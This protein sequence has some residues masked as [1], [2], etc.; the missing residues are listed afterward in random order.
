METTRIECHRRLSTI[1]WT[2]WL[3]NFTFSR[4]LALLFLSFLS[5]FLSRWSFLGD[6]LYSLFSLSTLWSLP[7]FSLWCL[8]FV[9]LCCT[10]GLSLWSLAPWS[11]S[12]SVLSHSGFS[13]LSLWCLF[14]CFLSLWSLCLVSLFLVSCRRAVTTLYSTWIL[15]V[16]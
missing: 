6:S 1:R 8:L 12:L 4:S 5:W 2:S 15:K 13:L 11:L 16:E 9:S 7:V 3:Y 10:P 14:P